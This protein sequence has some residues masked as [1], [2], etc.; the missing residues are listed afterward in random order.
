MVACLVVVAL[1]NCIYHE[2]IS[3]IPFRCLYR[4]DPWLSTLV[5]PAHQATVEAPPDITNS[6]IKEGALDGNEEV[7]GPLLD[8]NDDG[9]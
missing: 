8:E 1:I 9:W 6:D 5:L 7:L 3:C 4:R 2:T